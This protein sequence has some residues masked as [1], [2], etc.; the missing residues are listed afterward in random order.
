MSFSLL[1]KKKRCYL[2]ISSATLSVWGRL[3]LGLSTTTLDILTGTR[4]WRSGCQI[5]TYGFCKKM[6]L[7]FWIDIKKFGFLGTTVWDLVDLPNFLR[8]GFRHNFSEFSW[9]I[10]RQFFGGIWKAKNFGD[11]YNINFGKDFGHNFWEI[12]QNQF[13]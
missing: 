3:H 4:M 6:G 12:L 7:V 13:W 1:L 11:F 8:C 10:S 5:R 9:A 2:S